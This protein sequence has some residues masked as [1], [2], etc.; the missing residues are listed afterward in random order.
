MLM[1]LAA[2]TRK[3]SASATCSTRSASVSPLRSLTVTVYAVR[4]SA[5]FGYITILSPSP[6]VQ[7]V[8]RC[9]VAR[10][11]AIGTASTVCARSAP[12]TCRARRS[13]PAG[14]L[15]PPPPHPSTPRPDRDGPRRQ[16]EYVAALDVLAMRAV[17]LRGAGEPRVLGVDELGQLGLALAGRHRQG[18][19]RHPV[20]D[21]DAGVA[22]E[23]QVG[24]R[25]DE[26]VVVGEQAG[27]EP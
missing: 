14:G 20:A 25:V 17:D 16:Q 26:E 12:K 21:P 3:G 2:A 6:I 11:W 9:M 1:A 23:E 4:L 24:Q 7:T 10:S 13:A 15:P 19:D 22:R 27:H 5:T 18:G 8:S